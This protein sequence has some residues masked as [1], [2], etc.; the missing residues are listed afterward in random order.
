MSYL[1]TTR[2]TQAQKDMIENLKAK[3]IMRKKVSGYDLAVTQKPSIFRKNTKQSTQFSNC[4]DSAK[5]DLELLYFYFNHLKPMYR[6]RILNSNEFGSFIEKILYAQGSFHLQ[7]KE[8]QA[9]SLKIALQMLE[10]ARVVI[11]ENMPVEFQIVLDEASRPFWLMIKAIDTYQ[12]REKIKD[13][14]DIQTKFIDSTLSGF[15]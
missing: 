10:Y 14:P 5:A 4:V 6:L 2:Q 11:K 3:Y 9:R 13:S 8:E 1:M 15:S 7:T 12:K